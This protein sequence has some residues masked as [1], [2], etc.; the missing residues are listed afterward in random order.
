MNRKKKTLWIVLLAAL[1][2]AICFILPAT[3]LDGGQAAETELTAAFDRKSYSAGDDV[4]VSF[5]LRGEEFDA[6]GLCITFDPQ[7]MTYAGVQPTEGFRVAVCKADE[8]RLELIV[9]SDSAREPG[10]GLTVAT[11]TFRAVSGGAKT[12]EFVNGSAVYL[13]GKS[14]VA[15]NGYQELA[16]TG[17]VTEDAAA[18]AALHQ[19]IADA[20]ARLEA[21]IQEKLDSGVTVAQNELLLRCKQSGTVAIR[22]ARTQEAVAE[23]LSAAL[24][25]A[26]EIMADEAVEFPHL[27]SLAGAEERDGAVLDDIYPA[28]APENT[29]YFLYNNRPLEGTPRAF[30]ASVKQGVLVTFNGATVPVAA[31][32]SFRFAVPFRATENCST[33]VLKDPEAG[34][35]TTY[36]FY[37]FGYGVSGGPTQIAV[38]NEAGEKDKEN[39]G[40]IEQNGSVRRLS[41]STDRVRIGFRGAAEAN[42]VFITELV[43][44]NGRVLQTFTT[45]A[46]DNPVS[47]DF[48][49][50]TLTLRSG[51]NWFILRYKGVD[52]SRYEDGK[53]VETEAY[54]S[55]AILIRYTDSEEAERDP[56]LTD[57]KLNDIRIYLEGSEDVNR[58][59]PLDETQRKY[60]LTLDADAFDLALGRQSI[61]MTVEAKP[62]HT[63]SVYGGN[64]IAQERRLLKDGTYH[65]AD[66]LDTEIARSDSFKV[67]IT[68]TAKDGQHK[69]KYELTIEKKGQSAMIVPSI[70]RDREVVIVATNPYRTWNLVFASVGITDENG[71]VINTYTAMKDGRLTMKI[72]DPTVIDWDGRVSSGAFVIDLLRQ[73]ET[74]IQ[75]IYD[76]PDSGLHMEQP[77]YLSVN[78]SVESL[79]EL[80]T[81]ARELLKNTGGARVYADGAEEA[82][83]KVIDSAQ[84]VYDAYRTA[85]RRNLTQPQITEI[86]QAVHA[87]QKAMEDFRYA[88]IAIEIIAFEPLDEDIAYQRVDNDCP[89]QNLMLPRELRVTL[90]DGTTAVVKGVTWESDPT[91]TLKQDGDKRYLF[92][93]VLPAGYKVAR[94][95]ELPKIWIDRCAAVFV[96]DVRR[97]ALPLGCTDSR[98]LLIP[99]GTTDADDIL[100]LRMRAHVRGDSYTPAPTSWEILDEYD[101]GT[102]GQYRFRASLIENVTDPIRNMKFVW[103]DSVAAERRAMEMIVQVFDLTVNREALTMTVG[104]QSDV[105]R[106]DQADYPVNALEID[107]NVAPIY[108]SDR[109]QWSSSNPNAVAVDAKT[110][111]L[112]AKAPGTA[113]IIAKLEGTN[114]TAVCEVTVLSD[115]VTVQPARLSLTVG[116]KAKLRIAETLPRGTEITWKSADETIVSV[117]ETGLVT[118]VVAGTADITAEVTLNGVPL[119]GECT[120]VVSTGSGKP[121]GDPGG[122]PGGEPGGDPDGSG[123]GTLSGQPTG[124]GED[125]RDLLTDPLPDENGT[126]P[127]PAGVQMPAATQPEASQSP[128]DPTPGEQ[129]EIDGKPSDGNGTGGKGHRVFAYGNG[130]GDGAESTLVQLLS[131]LGTC[132]ALLVIG[133]L[134]GKKM[135]GE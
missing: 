89:L 65:I 86:N 6:A 70:Y 110:G 79:G 14:C 85:F 53:S 8:G 88:E 135:R 30:K 43:D 120:V 119:R 73:G 105:L 92:T 24:A 118:A 49:S 121:G 81:D 45:A 115:T 94:G 108:V 98:V 20:V 132:V 29:A 59:T 12:V 74:A 106:V 31:D 90:A 51:L 67:T 61:H 38:Y 40:E 1:V 113:S 83:R 69:D 2:A 54:R 13:G 4:S 80:L 23:A 5:I 7:S 3:A 39:I 128:E 66:Y 9:Q 71:E 124:G 95:V 76:D 96:F 28:F 112:T 10:A 47:Q 35:N 25:R 17:R 111:A 72:A 93:P 52:K 77:V 84:K 126:Q 62:G 104:E 107:D 99:K 101:G 129:P 50:D 33:L 117:D 60:K 22:S 131:T 15:Y 100:A 114:L 133:I 75:L 78:Y 122:E 116:E 130:D 27:L 87:L 42:K 123:G 16:V 63:V 55:Y 125:Y 57:T 26:E 82:L 56:T 11:A 32:G 68:V 102:V 21:D 127:N 41:T 91:Y 109:L 44:K 58:M 48:L 103:S 64:G 18:D 19:A 36:L 34:L 97:W 37:S 134:Y 46:D